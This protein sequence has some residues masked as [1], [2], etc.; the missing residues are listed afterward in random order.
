MSRHRKQETRQNEGMVD[1][2]DR[3]FENS[4]AAARQAKRKTSDAKGSRPGRKDQPS[5]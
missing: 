5:Q 2:Q 1:P 3:Q 4:R